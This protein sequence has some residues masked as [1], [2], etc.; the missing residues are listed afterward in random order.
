MPSLSQLSGSQ[1]PL[2]PPVRTSQFYGAVPDAANLVNLFRG[3]QP[4]D[5][6]L[7]AAGMNGLDLAI[8]ASY[9]SDPPAPRTP[10]T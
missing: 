2:V 4:A 10:G 9:D 7:V 8:Q 1:A 3:P 5:P 6:D